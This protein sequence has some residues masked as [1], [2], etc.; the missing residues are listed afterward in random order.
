MLKRIV[1]I[2]QYFRYD[3]NAH[4]AAANKVA[5]K[6][7]WSWDIPVPQAAHGRCLPG[8]QADSSERSDKTTQCPRPVSRATHELRRISIRSKTESGHSCPAVPRTGGA[9]QAHR[10]TVPSAATRPRNV[11]APSRGPR[12]NLDGSEF[13]QKRS[14]DIPVPQCQSLKV[15]NI[16]F[17]VRRS[18]FDV[19]RSPDG[20]HI[21][22]HSSRRLPQRRLSSLRT[23]AHAGTG[24]DRTTRPNRSRSR[25][26]RN[27]GRRHRTSARTGTQ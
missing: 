7:R 16:S 21:H 14:R 8:A 26:C 20:N 19:R 24:L 2:P 12:I 15:H 1:K 17:N 11:R 4:T 23:I 18:I 25:Q 10:R 22:H 3:T 5:H 6:N 13:G 9:Y 27:C